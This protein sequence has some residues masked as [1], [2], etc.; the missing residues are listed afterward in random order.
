MQI[1]LGVSNI[2]SLKS[3]TKLSDRLASG[4]FRDDLHRGVVDAGRKTKTKVQRAVTKQMNLKAGNYN[5][6]VVAGTRGISRKAILA[7]DIF[8]VKGGTDIDEYRGLRSVSK[9]NRLNVGRTALERGS[10]RSGVWNNPRIF[11][12]SFEANGNFYSMLPPSAGTSSRAPKVLWTFGRKPNQPRGAG[13]KFASSGV[14]YGKIR[15]LFGPA[16]MKE[17]PEDESL[18]TFLLFGPQLLELHVGKRL[19]KL[20]RF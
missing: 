5:K 19:E 13:G 12:R 8:G 17:I 18:D 6:Y 1:K 16:L 3:F 10:V 4:K 14:Q 7:F 15:R 11:K 9:R 2:S 20:M